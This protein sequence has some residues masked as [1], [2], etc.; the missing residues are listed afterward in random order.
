MPA[1]V[2]EVRHFRQ[3]LRLLLY[4]DAISVDSLERYD[5]IFSCVHWAIDS[6]ELSTEESGIIFGREFA[7]FSRVLPYKRS[8][9][10]PESTSRDEIRTIDSPILLRRG[11]SRVVFP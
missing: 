5:A 9:I 1:I 4:F 11:R 3:F 2:L 7:V 6:V 10:P 8:W